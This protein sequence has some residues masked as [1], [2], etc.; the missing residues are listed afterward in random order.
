MTPEAHRLV[1]SVTPDQL[2]AL[3]QIV[4]GA[5]V[6]GRHA[7]LIVSIQHALANAQ[8]AV[9]LPDRQHKDA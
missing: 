4:D 8:P 7:A 5:S 9:L 2:K 3:I 6:Q 1:V